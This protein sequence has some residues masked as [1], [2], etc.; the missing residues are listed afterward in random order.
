MRT[1]SCKP[2]AKQI[3]IARQ[4]REL[5]IP[6]AR[7]RGLVEAEYELVTL[8]DQVL[9]PALF[10][11]RSTLVSLRLLDLGAQLLPRDERDRWREEWAAE[12]ATL[13]TPRAR[14]RFCARTML[15]IPQLA[16]AVRAAPTWANGLARIARMLGIG[17]ALVA[18]TAPVSVVA[19]IAGA[20]ALVVV[21]VLTTLLFADSDAP[22]RR[23]ADLI[24][25]WRR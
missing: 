11:D 22:A 18:V 21:G 7:R 10:A 12:T 19:W 15:G 23:L 14:M 25:A 8:T 17:G 3:G 24:A 16:R 9:R 1:I 13:P 20:L 2:L 5:V 4:T 6:V